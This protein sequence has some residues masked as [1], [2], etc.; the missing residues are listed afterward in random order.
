MSFLPPDFEEFVT[1]LDDFRQTFGS[2]VT[3]LVPTTPT[4]PEG[5]AINPD[6]GTPYDAMIVQANAE[7][8]EVTMT[9]LII[10]K[11]A[12]PLRP[13]SDVRFEPAGQVESMDIII[14]ISIA[15]WA[16][17]NQASDFIINDKTYNVEENKPFSIGNE[18]WRVL[19]Y[20]AEH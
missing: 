8:T 14:D 20:G 18:E 11:E 7:Y 2:Q 12:S 6:T 16:T 1:V 5:T 4:W 3:F 10:V 13:G 9:C 17:V 19:V 15:D